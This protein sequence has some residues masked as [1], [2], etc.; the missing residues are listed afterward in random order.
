MDSPDTK[1]AA[2]PAGRSPR[3]FTIME[4]LVVV[5]IIAILAS[6]LVPLYGSMMAR[7]DE[8]RCLANLRNLYLGASGYLQTN[9]IWPQIPVNQMVDEPKTYARAWVTALKPHGTSHATWICPTIQRSFGISIDALEEE[10][11]YRIDFIAT[12]FGD[13]PAAPWAAP[14][15]PWFLEKSGVHSRGNLVI[16]ANGTTSSL[17]DLAQ[18]ALG[19]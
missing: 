10:Q 17:K 15:H 13:N 4:V 3:A 9:G 16:L 11:N 1:F 12:P 2:Q 19:K 6:M 18:I 14:T 8:A 7:A 5:V